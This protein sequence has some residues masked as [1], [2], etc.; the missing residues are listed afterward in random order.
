MAFQARLIPTLPEPP[1][2]WPWHKA[3]WRAISASLL[4]HDERRLEPDLYMSPGHGTR[5]AIESRNAGWARIGDIAEVWMPGRL[6]GVLVPPDHGMPFLSAMLAFSANPIPRKWLAPKQVQ[7]YEN[8]FVRDHMILVSCSGTVGRPIIVSDVHRERLI[9]HD[10]LRVE[11]HD[12]EQIGWIYAFLHS[13]QARAMMT[14][15][16]YGALVKHLETQ[17]LADLPIPLI[18]NDAASRF[19]DQTRRIV[20]LRNNAYRLALEAER[21]FEEALGEFKQSNTD[22]GGFSIRASAILGE[23]RRLEA[24][25][26]HPGVS[27]LLRH[28]RKRGKRITTLLESGCEV[29][30]PKRFKRISAENGVWMI[31]SSSLVEVNPRPARKIADIDFGD[32]HQGRVN[33][34]WLLVPRSGQVYGIL[35]TPVI[36][37]EALHNLV[38]SSD[39]IRVKMPMDETLRVGY[40]QIALSHPSLGRPLVKALAYGSSIPHIEVADLANLELV[41]L[42]PNLESKIADLSEASAKARARA[43]ELE[44]NIAA[45]ADAIIDQFTIKPKLRMVKGNLT[46]Q[47]HKMTNRF[48]TLADQWRSDRRRGVD[49]HMMI[50]HP[51]Y[52]EIIKMGKPAI[53]PILEELARKMDHWFPALYE[54]TGATP[55][56][57]EDRGKM[58]KM[59]D[60]WMEW[61]KREGY[62]L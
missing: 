48:K 47:Q 25:R 4:C 8:R 30:V 19:S 6:K 14:S 45:E 24:A 39:V 15:S 9:S 60:A 38:V 26:Y 18:D 11:A 10:L 58:E 56:S 53:R 36:A 2:E 44:K 27:Q 20:K 17:H 32:P 50:D 51:A 12:K 5:L 16:R 35:G 31:H 46:A 13:S 7:D 37:S 57:E 29:W 55:V 61:G 49:V 3:E 21:I 40:L 62:L 23:R 59:R 42:D 54:I 1:Q 41:R 52:Q 28:L 34:G 33:P 22:E 43:D